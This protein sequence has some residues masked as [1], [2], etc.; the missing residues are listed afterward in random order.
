[1]SGFFGRPYAPIRG[2]RRSALVESRLRLGLERTFWRSTIH[3]MPVR[4]G[5]TRTDQEAGRQIRCYEGG[6]L[7][8]RRRAAWEY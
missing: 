2:Q 3:A 5:H 7:R 4:F 1:M 8:E 6:I